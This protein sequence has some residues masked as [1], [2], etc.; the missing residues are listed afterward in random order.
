MKDRKE[1]LEE[2]EYLSKYSRTELDKKR[3]D[4][5][6]QML[7]M[8]SLPKE[9]LVSQLQSVRDKYVSLKSP[10][11]FQERRVNSGREISSRVDMGKE[12]S[13]YKKEVGLDRLEFQVSC[14]SE[15]LGIPMPKT[16]LRENV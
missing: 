6:K 7:A 11:R 9:T 4:A 16:S 5:V 10:V 2:L 12:V 3:K 8:Y 14:L 1:L 13:E 15:V